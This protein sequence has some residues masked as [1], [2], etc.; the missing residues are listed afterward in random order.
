MFMFA[1]AAL[2]RRSR[3]FAGV[4]RDSKASQ[5]IQFAPFMKSS[6][7]LT[8][9]AIRAPFLPAASTSGVLRISTLRR[10]MRR[11]TVSSPTFTAYV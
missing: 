3:Y 10:P 5:G 8:L 1:A 7:L 2:S 6:R 11:V 4:C 9:T